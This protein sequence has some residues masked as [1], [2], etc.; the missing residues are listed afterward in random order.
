[1]PSWGGR[2]TSV[3]DPPTTHTHT[4][5]VCATASTTKACR[6]LPREEL[7][8]LREMQ[9]DFLEEIA[10][11]PRFEGRTETM[12]VAGSSQLLCDCVLEME[13]SGR[14]ETGAHSARPWYWAGCGERRRRHQGIAPSWPLSRTV[15][16]GAGRG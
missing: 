9:K 12:S 5:Q 1:M 11:E 13:R 7:E 2:L 4:H 3:T 14:F 8:L 15:E 16:S 6:A 10:F